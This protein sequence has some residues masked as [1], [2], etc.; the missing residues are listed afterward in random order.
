MATRIEKKAG[1]QEAVL[2]TRATGRV[3]NVM[4]RTVLRPLP[5]SV[6]AA[7]GIF[8]GLSA[9][10]IGLVCVIVHGLVPGDAMFSS[11]GTVLLVVAIPMIL[12]GSIFLDEIK[13]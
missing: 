9:L 6:F 10:F 7:T 12:I 5:C 3:R 13:R 8:G 4:R 1:L 2:A 11:V